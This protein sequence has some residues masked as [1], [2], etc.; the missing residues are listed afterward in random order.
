MKRVIALVLI[1]M[2]L[3]TT[4]GYAS[5]TKYEDYALKLK[6]IGVFTGTN[7]GFELD[8]APTRIEAAV[9][10]VRLL[11]AEQE[12]QSKKY[13]H[14]FTDV[15]GWA[16]DYVG[17]LYHEKL[18][19]GIGETTFGSTD[20]M[21]AKSYMTFILRALGYSDSAGD[22]TWNSAL[23]FAKNQG[24]LNGPDYNELTT[25]AFLRD[26]VAKVSYDALK[27][28]IKDSIKIL[29]E[30]LVETNAIAVEKAVTIG[31]LE[32]N[33]NYPEI[34][35]SS[36]DQLLKIE[37]DP[38]KGFNYPFYLYVPK[39]VNQSS[40]KYMLVEPNNTGEVNDE[41]DV[42]DYEAKNLIQE[43]K[44]NA[45]A[46]ELDIPLLVPVFPR[47]DS[48][49]QIYTHALDRD[50]LIIDDDMMG[51]L[52]LQLINMIDYAQKTLA[53]NDKEV[54]RK[55][56]M[57]GFS[58]SGN[59]ANRFVALHPERVQAAVT[60][61]VNCMP[62]LPVAEYEGNKLIY[63]I[64]IGDIKEIADIN[65][66]LEEYKNVAQYIYMGYLDDNDTLF[67][68]DA[69]D[70]EEKE[71]ILKV[72][73]GDMHD[74]WQKS[75]DVIQQTGAN[76]QFVMYNNTE[77]EIRNEM[78]DDII[79][80]L[81]SNT[82]DEI[83]HIEPHE[84]SFVEREEEYKEM[85]I[86][87][88]ITKETEGVDPW[89]A[90][91]MGSYDVLLRPDPNI[92]VVTP[93]DEGTEEAVKQREAMQLF[94]RKA[95]KTYLEDINGYRYEC[96]VNG[97]AS[98]VFNDNNMFFIM[99]IPWIPQGTYKIIPENSTEGYKWI[100]NTDLVISETHFSE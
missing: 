88:I 34:N 95:G 98:C 96:K 53:S 2:M 16:S 35:I 10:F 47:L 68:Y 59:F 89:H 30:Q 39:N 87:S 76:P 54:N 99:S 12:A 72:L 24:V 31:L 56:F 13:S 90:G 11:G 20:T 92:K 40:I 86:G 48:E 85:T 57:S 93:G 7:A 94:A 28:S 51:R 22:F 9:M 41:F 91:M 62:I 17:Y 6:E 15:P 67:Y 65:F 83:V 43:G 60:G 29:V 18:S 26:H 25:Q 27:T 79:E 82:S 78:L 66:N 32:D 46:D 55:V 44:P 38:S 50:S 84:Y 52:D 58:A 100:F 63:P 45:I 74:R 14:P 80:F 23:E 36:R 4:F 19:N 8:R 75:I 21:P 1:I 64:G 97:T 61:G 37:A 5:L 69:F 42:H 71:L 77:H 49:W 33:T 73:G 3:T 70:D 81:R